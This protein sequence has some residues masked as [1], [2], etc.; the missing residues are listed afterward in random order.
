MLLVLFYIYFIDSMV[1][2]KIC[3]WLN[4]FIDD[5][6]PDELLDTWDCTKW[7]EDSEVVMI[8]NEIVLPTFK[9]N[10]AHTDA[11]QILHTLIWEYFQFR[12]AEAISKYVDDTNAY[13]RLKNTSS[14]KCNSEEW[15]K[16]RNQI[17]LPNEF[18]N[19]L[20]NPSNRIH[21]LRKKCSNNISYDNPNKSVWA[22]FKHITGKIYEDLYKHQIFTDLDCI[23][24]SSLTNLASIPDGIIS[25]GKLI[26][27]FCPLNGGL[28]KDDIP[29]EHY[30]Q[31]QIELEICNIGAIDY[32]E[33]KIK[34][35]AT[36]DSDTTDCPSGYAGSIIIYSIA[37]NEEKLCYLYSPLFPNTCSGRSDA[38]KWN[39]RRN[40]SCSSSDNECQDC[41]MN[42]DLSGN[43]ELITCI[44]CSSIGI[45]ILE[46]IVWQTDKWQNTTVLRNKRWWSSVALNEY[47]Q[48]WLDVKKSQD[49]P[50]YLTPDL[51]FSRKAMFLDEDELFGVK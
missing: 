6:Q 19:I 38:M 5:E 32:F 20:A 33:C 47:N 12:K 26:K 35:G 49:D 11:T 43:A 1:Y 4:D 29:Y 8:F 39:P 27:L 18:S 42:I 3:E 40:D 36:W 22:C 21:L 41:R 2:S 23:K 31:M 9:T 37:D 15:L 45:K 51:S 30:C 14:I 10:R 13:E 7:I 48:F 16:M 34:S 46:K 24:H 17:L 28:Y 25:N 44:K 50:M